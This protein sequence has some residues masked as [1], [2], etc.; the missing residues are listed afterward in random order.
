MRH[1]CAVLTCLLAAV[2]DSAC[3]RAPGR[4]G[5]HAEAILPG[6]ITDF[7]TLYEQNCAGCH[8][9]GGKGGGAVSLS[10]PMFLAIADDVT[11]RR[12]AS[13]GVAGTPM[14]AF[15]QSA[16]G[17]LTDRQIDAI[18]RGIRT[19]ANPA[20]VEGMALPPYA[21]T[22]PGNPIAGAKVYETYCSACH[23]PE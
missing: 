15:A 2:V 16:G 8:G 18:V 4:P 10:N 6:E 23:G 9:P 17:M 3:D 21:P 22:A 7:K 13:F 19:W 11:I 1:G 5:R 12:T 14:P 20:A